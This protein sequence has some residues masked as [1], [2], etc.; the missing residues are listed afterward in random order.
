MPYELVVGGLNRDMGDKKYLLSPQDLAGIDQVPEVIRLGVVSFKIEG[1]LK[2][3]EYVAAVTRAYRHAIDA[4]LSGHDQ[5]A[6][7]EERYEL[8]MVFS[9]GLLSGWLN[10][11]NNKKLV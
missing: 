6:G 2:T 9:R 10:G 5:V 7:E 1:R 11:I 4:A 3:P 8:E